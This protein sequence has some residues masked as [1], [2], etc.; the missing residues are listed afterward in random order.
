TKKK[1][2]VAVYNHYVNQVIVGQVVYKCKASSI[3]Y[4]EYWY[5]V[6][7]NIHVSPESSNVLAIKCRG[8]SLHR[9]NLNPVK[10][11]S[12]SK[13]FSCIAPYF[14]ALAVVIPKTKKIT[15]N[16]Y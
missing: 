5:H 12:S 15:E 4:V 11:S 9:S 14:C 2:W 6:V 8:C 3:I 10:Y 13:S 7:D 16:E 1:E